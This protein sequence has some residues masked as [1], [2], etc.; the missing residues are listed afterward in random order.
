MCILSRVIEILK[1]LKSKLAKSTEFIE[2]NY[3]YTALEVPNDPDYSKQWNM[4]SINVESAWDENKGSGV[5]VP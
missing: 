3:I 2:P 4:R 5:T 1:A